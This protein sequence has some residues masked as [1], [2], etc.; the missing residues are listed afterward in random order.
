MWMVSGMA[1]F[2]APLPI[3]LRRCSNHG[4]KGKVHSKGEIVIN[5]DGKPNCRTAC[6]V[7]NTTDGF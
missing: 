1:Y 6:L 2:V 7:N 3:W 5:I 4:G